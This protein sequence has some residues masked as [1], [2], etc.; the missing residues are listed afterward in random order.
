M[1]YL[2]WLGLYIAA[3]VASQFLTS[4]PINLF[5]IGSYHIWMPLS[6]LTVVPLVDV[7]RCFTQ[8]QSELEKRS[9]RKTMLQML[10]LSMLSAAVCVEFAGLPIQIFTGVLGAVTVGCFTDF[11]VFNAMSKVTKHPV[12]RMV[13]SNLVTTLI[14]SGV[15][16]FTAF[17]DWIFPASSLTMP[18]D[19]VVVGWLSQSL[20]IWLSGLLI[21]TCLN[22]VIKK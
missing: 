11:I 6:A 1:S 19:E 13:V 3:S 5:D 17:T 8:Y 9:S 4:Q 15:V 21:A 22:K 16:L 7:L 20:F 10:G 12:K 14:G 2:I 18:T